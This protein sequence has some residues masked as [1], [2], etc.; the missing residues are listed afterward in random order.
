MGKPDPVFDRSGR[1]TCNQGRSVGQGVDSKI[2]TPPRDGIGMST[3]NTGREVPN[4]IAACVR[5]VGS[6]AANV[7]RIA[8]RI[9]QTTDTTAIDATRGRTPPRTAYQA[10]A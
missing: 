2:G 7:A 8:M 1:V 10:P 4:V 9:A 3:A 6:V 5:V